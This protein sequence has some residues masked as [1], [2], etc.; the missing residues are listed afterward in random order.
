MSLTTEQKADLLSKKILFSKA[1]SSIN[2]PFFE[3]LI[4]SRK[5]VFKT[6]IWSE[7]DLIPTT[8]AAVPN[9]VEV[10]TDLSLTYLAGEDST[11]FYDPTLVDVISFTHGDGSYMYTIKTN[12]DVVIPFG[13]NDWYL[14]PES[15]VLMFHDGFPAGVD[16]ST[17]PKIS[18]YKYIGTKGEIGGASAFPTE[19]IFIPATGQTIFPLAFSPTYVIELSVGGIEQMR[20]VDYTWAGSTLSW[21]STD[22]SLS[23]TKTVIIKYYK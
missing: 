1:M 16:E 22:F 20:I 12:G 11:A 17:P 18:C 23:A 15:G 13:T 8:A 9:I 10:V 5:S 7:S 21:V 6:D 14:D 4:S 3:E 19:E 2:K